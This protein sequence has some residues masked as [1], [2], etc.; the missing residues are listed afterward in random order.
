[1]SD[2][3]IGGIATF[4][5]FVR[6]DPG[7]IAVEFDCS[8]AFIE[9]KLNEIAEDLKKREGIVDVKIKPNTGRLN[10]GEQIAHFVVAGAHREEILST[11]ADAIDRVKMEVHVSMREIKE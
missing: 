4:T 2:P 8:D 11:L 10:V 9:D 3:R 1:M 5:G 7:V 6:G